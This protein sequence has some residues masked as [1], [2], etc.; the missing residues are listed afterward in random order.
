MSTANVY[1]MVGEYII[2]VLDDV[3]K[4]AKIID[5]RSLNKTNQACYLI[6]VSNIE[7]PN[8]K[9]KL[10]YELGSL[11]LPE[12]M[13][14]KKQELDNILTTLESPKD[15]NGDTFLKVEGYT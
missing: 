13:S 7:I 1:S 12:Y 2:T 11:T 6:F 10:A 5:F 15:W 8:D 4:L 14:V 9:L 3:Y